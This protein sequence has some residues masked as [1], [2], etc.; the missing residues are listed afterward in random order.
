MAYNCPHCQTAIPDAVSKGELQKKIDRHNTASD[1]LEKQIEALT[2][3]SRGA[4]RSHKAAL[5]ALR[6]ELTSG[7]ASALAMAR[8]GLDDDAAAVAELLHGRLPAD[9]RPALVDWLQGQREDPTTAHPLLRTYFD[10]PAAPVEGAPAA[11]V[12]AAPAAG[13]PSPTGRR[14]EGVA[15][16]W[17]AAQVAGM[18]D[19]EFL[20]NAAAL[21]S[22][23]G[24]DILGSFG[25]KTADT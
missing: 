11:T 20:T 16:T 18:S 6:E 1:A 9:D 21:S 23:V 25:L 2:K 13:L 5:Q 19:Q 17:T 14:V 24:Y 8:I 3:Q 12:E 22:A 10:A 15:P 7:H 4:E